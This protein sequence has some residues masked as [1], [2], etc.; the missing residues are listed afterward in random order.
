MPVH[1]V[2]TTLAGTRRAIGAARALAEAI[3]SRIYVL[4]Q[5]RIPEATTRVAP[6]ETLHQFAAA[7]RESPEAESARIDLVACL[8]RHATD[9]IP[10][11]PPKPLVFIGG[12]SRRWWPTRE[13]R[14]AD[15]FRRLGCRV[16]YVCTDV[17]QAA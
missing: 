9:M 16:I 13:Q 1:V 2:S 5:N 4:V 17:E 12:G 3:E 6:T 8:S 15:H 14:L 7:I 11:L 10:L